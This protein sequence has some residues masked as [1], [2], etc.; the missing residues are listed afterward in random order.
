MTEGLGDFFKLLAEDK[1][2][3]KDDMKKLVGEVDI[4]SIFS[5]VKESIAEDHETAE[6]VSKQAAVFESWLFSDSKEKKEEIIVEEAEVF[7]EEVENIEPE[8]NVE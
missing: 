1:K 2:K 7:R 4:D 6:K 8:P 3:K 5:Q